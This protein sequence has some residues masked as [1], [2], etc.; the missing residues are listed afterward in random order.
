MASVWHLNSN[1]LA[2]CFPDLQ[3]RF[4]HFSS[5]LC[6]DIA[7]RS[8]RLSISEFDCYRRFSTASESS[9]Y[10]FA[11]YSSKACPSSFVADLQSRSK[12]Y[13]F[14]SFFGKRIASFRAREVEKL[15]TISI[16][17]AGMTASMSYVLTLAV[18]VAFAAELIFAFPLQF[19]TN[20]ISG[21]DLHY[22]LPQWP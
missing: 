7:I 10:D 2:D 19:R 14:E 18:G 11:I 6:S 21:F 12:L 13:A 15:K 16:V 3:L 9:R 4:R 1:T 17:R 5:R 8:S 22:V 20:P